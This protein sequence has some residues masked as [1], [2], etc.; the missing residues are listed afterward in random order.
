MTARMRNE[1]RVSLFVLL[2]AV[3]SFVVG[4]ARA[5]EVAT[6]SDAPRLAQ[7][8]LKATGVQG[9]LVVHLGCGDGALTAALRANDRYLVHGLDRDAADVAKARQLIRRRGLYGP[10]S[11]DRLTTDRLPYADNLA[12]LVVCEDSEGIA[13]DE[14][15]RVLAPGGVAVTLDAR[16]STFD[17][18]QKAWPAEMD[19]W[20]H[21]LHD[22]SNNAVA[23]DTLIGPPTSMQW[24]AKPMYCRSHEIDSSLPALVSARGRVFYILDE[25]LPGIIDERLPS[26]WMLVARDAFSG[27]LLWKRP[28]PRWGWREWKREALEGKDWTV[29]RGQRMRF[30]VEI[31]RRLVAKGDRVY[32]TLSYAAGL[33]ILDAATGEVVQ[34]CEGTE[35]TDEIVLA[36]GTVVIRIANRLAKKLNRRTGKTAPEEIAAVDARTG[37]VVWR[38][39]TTPARPLSLAACDGRVVFHTQNRLV[40]LELESGRELWQQKAR[41]GQTLVV[42]DGVV[43]VVDPKELRAFSLD[44]GELLWTGPGARGPGA[45]SSTDLFVA[46][47]LVWLGQAVPGPG[48]AELEARYLRF[49]ETGVRMVGYDVKTGEVKKTIEVENLVS[50]GHHFRCHRSKATSRY[51]LWPK[52]GVEFIDLEGDNHMRHDWLRGSCSYGLMPANGMIYVPPHQC[53]CYVGPK[54]SGFLALASR[55]RPDV[56]PNA[57]ER[58]ERGPAYLP[59]P[60]GEGR[61]EG[62]LRPAS[63][64]SPLSPHPSSD[65][66]TFRHDARR[67]GSTTSAV[68][69]KLTQAWEAPLSGRLTQ[70]VVAEGRLLVASVDE[71]TV[72]ALDARD[73]KPLWS[74]TAGSRID[75][76]PTVY[77]VPPSGGPSG[78]TQGKPP[79]GGT[80]NTLCL[81]GSADGWVY[82]LRVADG[83]L[84]WRFRAAPE[85]RRVVAFGQLESAWPVHGSVLV[86]DDVAYFAAGRSSYLDGGIHVYGVVPRS[87]EL[88]Y[89]TC[90]EGP[91]PDLSRD[92]GRPFDM[93]GAQSDVLVTD[94]TYVYMQETVLDDKLVEQPAPRITAMGDRKMG[95]HVFST[96]GLLDDTWWNRTFWMY[97]ERWPGF[98]IGNQA[99]KAGQLLVVGHTATYAVKCY[100]RRNMHSPM[101]FPGTSGYLLFADDNDNEPVLYGQPGAAK[102]LKWLPDVKVEPYDYKGNHITDRYDDFTFEIDK[103]TGFTRAEPPVWAQWVPVRIRG[104]VLAG[105]TLFVAGPPDVLDPKDPLAAFEG[106]KGGALWAVSAKDGKKLAEY[107]L[108]SPPVFDG[109]I[110][111]E[112]RLYISTVGGN[113][114]CFYGDK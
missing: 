21:F 43:L 64:P 73:G 49:A 71:H 33:S 109:L 61:G 84:V 86:K 54:L 6:G 77:R 99:P 40:C 66:P 27:V 81:F 2:A 105:D 7:E 55:P 106:R 50:P 102:P 79:E 58:L 48:F 69:S 89:H 5:Q 97:S 111:A 70:P 114:L 65:W 31:A 4:T 94:G 95:R 44:S 8:I 51:I 19:E 15:L 83:K 76:P 36:D 90:V 68:A 41:S 108:E 35:G 20:T 30:P 12:Q 16:R 85:D 92:V 107:T 11:V 67:T 13:K 42:H 39:A 46:K 78:A 28:L 56:A 113:V 9:G 60:L 91:Y 23:D 47:G 10:V 29:L 82:C 1:V 45:A 14:L 101:F 75:S 72:Y 98:Y 53:F 112:G 104:M 25:G 17:S 34:T 63:L 57:P 103:G 96:A 87:G 18:F 26:Q 24:V 100:T 88:L 93:E 3:G 37:K 62:G 22:A 110:A 32:T 59:L 38:H 52:R 80:T 74:Y